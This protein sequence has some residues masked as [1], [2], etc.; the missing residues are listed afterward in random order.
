M[1]EQFV[2]ESIHVLQKRFSGIDFTNIELIAALIDVYHIIAAIIERAYAGY[3]LSPQSIDVLIPLYIQGEKGFT[4]R[5][6]SEVI[7]VSQ[8]NMTGRVDGLIRKGLVTRT[9]HPEDRRKRVVKLT[10]KGKAL[11]ECFIPDGAKF[12]Q[13]LLSDMS[14]EEKA[15]LRKRVVSLSQLLLPFWEKRVWLKN[16]MGKTL[17]ESLKEMKKALKVLSAGSGLQQ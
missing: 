6:I 9:E 1:Q 13:E 8:S 4:L 3:R 16:E 17:P 11:I 10:E 2:T 5:E 15:E 7:Y 12:M 14:D